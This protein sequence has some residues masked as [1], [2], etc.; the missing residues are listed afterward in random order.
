MIE[1]NKI[2]CDLHPNE[3][4]SNYCSHCNHPSIQNNATYPSAPPA[5]A[6]TLKHTSK[7]ERP[8]TTKT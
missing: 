7:E 8:P 4:I 3:L 5:S 1:F 2:F 6:H